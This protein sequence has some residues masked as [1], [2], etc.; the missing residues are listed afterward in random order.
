MAVDSYRL[1]PSIALAGARELIEEL[2]GAPD[3]IAEAVGVPV[4]ALIR[5]DHPLSAETIAAF[6]ERAAE[7]CHCSHFGVLLASRQG[8]QT[9]GQVWLLMQQAET[10]E[11]AL[12]D[13][14]KYFDFFTSA[15][16][17]DLQPDPDGIAVCY[18]RRPTF[19]GP[20]VQ[21]I[22]SGLAVA[23]LEITRLVGESW[24]PHTVQFRHSAPASLSI[25]K[26]V[27]GSE[28]YFEQDRNAIIVDHA[29]LKKPMSQ[30]SPLAHEILSAD[31]K[32]QAVLKSQ[33]TATKAES[34]IRILL[35]TSNCSLSTV[36]NYLGMSPRSVQSHLRRGGSSYQKVLKQVRLEQAENYLRNSSLRIGHIAEL[37][38][39]KD[40]ST[41]SRF[42][43]ANIGASPGE[44]RRQG[45]RRQ[46][47]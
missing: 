1:I 5:S 15:L 7:Q 27:F 3:E 40:L 32:T 46:E 25:H 36:S 43:K 4:E 30:S 47:S 26:R 41:F 16:S 37:L 23:T 34:A 19:K 39:Y 29:T 18:E 24:R 28:I 33:V 13:L 45:K 42:I 44:I 17:I 9:L 31:F 38:Q 20:I 21:V 14:S 35:Q 2:G 6:F 8:W 11:A 12:V 22:E 10:V